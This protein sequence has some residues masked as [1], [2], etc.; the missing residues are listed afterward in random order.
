MYNLGSL[1]DEGCPAAD[2]RESLRWLRKA[3]ESG[4]GNA[5]NNAANAYKTG[6]HGIPLDRREAFNWSLKGALLG[7]A[8]CQCTLGYAYYNGFGVEPDYDRP[9]AAAVGR[10]GRRLRSALG[11][12]RPGLGR[13]RA[14]AAAALTVGDGLASAVQPRRVLPRRSG[15]TKDP[16]ASVL[17]SLADRPRFQA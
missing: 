13:A 6:R 17:F 7:I 12:V 9:V 2:P 16:V 3:C 14:M 11:Y 1:R 10:A 5:C 15:L 4:H 8:P